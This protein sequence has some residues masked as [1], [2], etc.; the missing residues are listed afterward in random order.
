VTRGCLVKSQL[1]TTSREFPTELEVQIDTARGGFV[2]RRD[3][4]RVDFVSPLPCPFNY[5]SVPETR[6]SDG[7][8]EDAIVLG[9]RL[10]RG[11]RVRMP[12][13]ARV[14][15]LD[16]G[17]PDHK[18]VCGMQI[19]KA[20]LRAIHWFFRVY[21][22]AKRLLNMLRGEFRRTCYIGVELPDPGRMRSV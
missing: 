13:L 21:G 7:D 6:A 11:S 12:V 5:G 18:W 9:G 2:K 19:T 20:D 8:R 3:D 15:F 14:R 22:Q 16:G 10:S 1:V 4:G 17:V